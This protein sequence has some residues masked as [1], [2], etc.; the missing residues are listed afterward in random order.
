MD[1]G[2]GAEGEEGGRRGRGGGDKV[3]DDDDGNGMRGSMRGGGRQSESEQLQWPVW[4][5]FSPQQFQAR[6]RGTAVQ[7]AGALALQR[8]A[9]RE[10]E[11]V[12]CHSSLRGYGAL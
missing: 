12:S 10:N 9:R 1:A 7:L 3:Q 6:L 4:S 5:S 8:R 11:A 2:W